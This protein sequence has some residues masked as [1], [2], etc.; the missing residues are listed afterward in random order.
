MIKR[1]GVRFRAENVF[2]VETY[3]GNLGYNI[4]P[5]F[6]GKHLAER[7]CRLLFPLAVAHG[8]EGFGSL[9]IP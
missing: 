1:S 3:A 9:A 5:P 4:D 2:D 6:R 7:A 8:F